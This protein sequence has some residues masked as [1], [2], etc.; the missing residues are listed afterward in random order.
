VKTNRRIALGLV[1]GLAFGLLAAAT[2]SRSLLGIAKGLEPVGAVFGNLVRM[3]VV[4]LVAATVFTGVARLGD[5][6]QLG[7]LGLVTMTFFWS[8]LLIAIVTG[9]AVMSLFVPLLPVGAMPADT[10]SAAER[11]PTTADFVVSLVPSNVVDAAAKGA[12]LPMIVF[13]AIFGAAAGAMPHEPRQRLVDFFDAVT[14]AMIVVVH[15]ALV[16]APIG[17]F[18]LSASATAAFGWAML[19]SLALLVAAT[20]VGLVAFYSLVYVP[21]VKFIGGIPASRF[22]KACV[23]PVSLAF[24]TTSSAAT[25]PALYESAAALGLSESVSS[26]V[27][28]L[29]SAINRTGS[30]LFQGAAVV[31]FA[32]VY[33]V[34]LSTSA[35]VGAV[36]TI[37]VIAQTVAGVPSAG[38]VTLAPALTT[39]GIPVGGL[40]LLL[41]IDRL[42][43]MVRTAT[44]VTGHLAAAAVVERITERSHPERGE[45]SAVDQGD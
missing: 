21:A 20:L 33:G 10:V 18:A 5:L 37:F 40:P 35:L 36:L 32:A 19:K 41:G 31:F 42:P 14:R 9:M 13:V 7:R 23:G 30:A 28:S 11:L 34:P 24:A 1:F 17:V 26:F 25:L 16:V 3:V 6:R 38:V 45:G 12:L 8:T 39:M 27:L 29:G 44:Q 43:D 15:W 4:P 2:G 22:L